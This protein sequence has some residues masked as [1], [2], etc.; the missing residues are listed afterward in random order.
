[1]H[2]GRRAFGSAA[3]TAQN[4]QSRGVIDAAIDE[5]ECRAPGRERY[6]NDDVE[7]DPAQCGELSCGSI[8]FAAA[9]LIAEL[10]L[11]QT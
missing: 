6:E 4:K 1:M 8:R 11:F 7:R 3:G 9:L 2:E 10:A 5:E